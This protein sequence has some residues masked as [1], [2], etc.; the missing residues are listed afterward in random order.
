V[1]AFIQYLFLIICHAFLVQTVVGNIVLDSIP[2]DLPLPKVSVHKNTADGYIFAALPYWG[3]GSSYLVIYDNTGKPVSYR[4]MTAT[5]TDFKKQDNGLLTYYDYASKK[6]FG[7]DSSL[8]IVD[9]FWVSNG[10]TTDEHDIKILRNGHVLLIGYDIR[11]YDMSQYIQGGDPHASVI[12]NVIQEIDNEKNVVFEWKAYEH[13]KLTDV[14]PAVNLSDPSFV[15]T[16]INSIDVDLDDNLIISTKNLDEITKIDHKAGTIIWRWGGKNNQ[17]T[18]VNDSIGFS[19]QHSVSVLPNGNLLVYDNGLFH[20]PHFSRACE[21]RLDAMNKTATMI[22][23]YRNTPDVASMFWG[24]A[25][26]L[27][28][29]NTFISWGLSEIAVTEVSPEGEKVFEMSFPKDVFSYRVFRFPVK[30]SNTVSTIG[31]VNNITDVTLHQNFPNPFNSST[32]IVYELPQNT[33]VT[34]KVYDILG[35]EV[36]TLT[37]EDNTAGQHHAVADLQSLPS[38]IYFYRMQAGNATRLRSMVYLR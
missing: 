31:V 5:C 29:G 34:L 26:R 8:A 11:F 18:F 24:N 2:S 36:K 32:T 9:S 4:K 35:R 1:K 33:H 23:S 14:G 3:Y 13:Y 19:A 7:M 15:H 20:K 28:N 37:D 38:G 16:H 6:F 21:Y 25:Q 10:F 17:F 22:W 30:I 12:V 27:Q